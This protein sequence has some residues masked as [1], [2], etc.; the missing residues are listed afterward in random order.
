MERKLMTLQ[1]F[2]AE[3]R[4]ETLDERVYLVAPVVAVVTG[5][6]NKELLR[7]QDL[8][9]VPIDAWADL[10]LPIAH[11]EDGSG[12]VTARDVAIVESQVCGRFYNTRYETDGDEIKLKGELWVDVEKALSLGVDGA[13]VVARLRAG[14]PLEVSTAYTRTVIEESGSHAGQAYATIATEIRPDHLALLPNEIGACSWADGCGAPRVNTNGGPMNVNLREGE[15]YAER[16]E[17]VI[18]A[19]REQFVSSDDGYTYIDDLYKNEVVYCR[20]ANN[21]EADQHFRVGYAMTGDKV[22]F[23]GI[24]SEVKRTVS[25][26]ALSANVRSAARTPKYVGVE[27]TSWS[28]PSLADMIAG[29]VKH[30]GG[31]KPES[32]ITKDLPSAVKT[33]IASKSLLGEATADD[34]RDLIFFPVVNPSTDKLN[35]NAL[36]AVLGGRGAQADIPE[37]AK[38]SAQAKARALLEKEFKMAKQAANACGILARIKRLLGVNEMS[39]EEMVKVLG[40][41]G[42]DD[43]LIE[44]TSDAQLAWMVEHSEPV[45]EPPVEPVVEP[46]VEPIVPATPDVAP[47]VNADTVIDGVK[48]GEIARFITA[49]K[50][51]IEAEKQSLVD[52][53]VANE[54][55]TISKETLATLTPC[56]LKEITAN[57][58]PGN[59]SGVGVPRGAAQDIP[60]APAVVLAKAVK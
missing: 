8:L 53:L 31:D 3:V 41:R 10:P 38:E 25:Y 42:V 13:E 9:E 11:P 30:T 7:P 49:H 57:F 28:A 50:G 54:R 35:E 47:A 29:Y 46:V 23:A 60:A 22:V 37:A 55:C 20:G 5:V 59:Y 15:S 17:A 45:V 16:S 6:L 32:S 2:T 14:K 18:S 24:P 19:V 39:R 26:T 52:A 4:E 1:S 36:R 58:Q 40:D 43:T 12:Y 56:V 27:T 21:N 48:L 51:D 33:W 34:T 44:N